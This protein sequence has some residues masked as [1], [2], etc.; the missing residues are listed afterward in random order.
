MSEINSIA[1]GTYTLGQ[2]S[3]TTFEAGNGIS[4]TQPSE[5]TV[6]ISNDETVLYS[7]AY[8]NAATLSDDLRNYTTFKAFVKIGQSD[9]SYMVHELDTDAESWGLVQGWGESTSSNCSVVCIRLA[10]DSANNKLNCTNR[11]ILN[12]GAWNN[13][14]AT[15]TAS[16][17]DNPNL[18]YKVI[19]INRISGGNA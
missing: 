14:T 4:I 15:T 12:F 7:G 6:R 2:T 18:I 9:H 16:Y 11:K 1:Q 5:G 10:Y 3:A 17:F 8:T 19:G 13:N